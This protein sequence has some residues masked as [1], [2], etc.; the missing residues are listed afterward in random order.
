MIVTLHGEVKRLSLSLPQSF[1]SELDTKKLHKNT[2]IWKECE[3]ITNNADL[4]IDSG[5]EQ[6]D[7]VELNEDGSACISPRTVPPQP[8]TDHNRKLRSLGNPD[9]NIHIII[10]SDDEKLMD[11]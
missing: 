7:G 6:S 9:D 5:R 10:I 1:V 3:A 11:G 2:M 4:S 8:R